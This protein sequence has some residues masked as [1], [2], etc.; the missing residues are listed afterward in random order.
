ML[1][2]GGVCSPGPCLESGNYVVGMHWGPDSWSL[3]R[4]KGLDCGTML[5][6]LGGQQGAKDE[7]NMSHLQTR[8]FGIHLDLCFGTHLDLWLRTT[9]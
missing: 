5:E 2:S 1:D 9:M 3:L 4:S 8:V 6:G 7:I